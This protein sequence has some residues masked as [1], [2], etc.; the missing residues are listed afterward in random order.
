MSQSS[1]FVLLQWGSNSSILKDFLTGKR[2]KR[3][4]MKIKLPPSKSQKV[5]ETSK[6]KNKQINKSFLTVERL[7]I[8]SRT[9]TSADK[10]QNPSLLAAC[11]RC[12]N[13]SPLSANIT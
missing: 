9:V 2:W 13:G 10:V 11:D 1:L 12:F 8:S 5:S 3:R 6:V 4:I 7:P